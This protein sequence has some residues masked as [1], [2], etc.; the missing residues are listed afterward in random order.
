M[1]RQSLWGMHDSVNYK[2]SEKGTKW[3]KALSCIDKVADDT[4]PDQHSHLELSARCAILGTKAV[5][6]QQRGKSLDTLSEGVATW[7]PSS[8]SGLRLAPR[9]LHF[10]GGLA[11]EQDAAAWLQAKARVRREVRATRPTGCTPVGLR[12]CSMDRRSRLVSETG[13]RTVS[14]R[15]LIYGSISLSPHPNFPA[16]QKQHKRSQVG[17]D[18]TRLITRTKTTAKRNTE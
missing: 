17:V 8:D 11:S 9:S 1:S 7:L 15:K 18:R 13:T 14:L 16:S 4:T 5:R 6:R 2:Y 3:H 12:N 10:G